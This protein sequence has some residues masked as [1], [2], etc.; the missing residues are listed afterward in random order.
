M[1]EQLELTLPVD[2]S[3]KAIE[4]KAALERA[5]MMMNHAEELHNVLMQTMR[6]KVR[7][8]STEFQ[9]CCTHPVTKIK[10]DFDYHKREEWKEEVC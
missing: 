9:K 1:A 7:T 2:Q 8:L 3:E 4:I 6:E 10:D 5:R